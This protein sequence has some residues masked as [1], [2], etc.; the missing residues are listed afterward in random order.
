MTAS[1]CEMDEIARPEI[2]EPRCVERY[3]E[4]TYAEHRARS[5]IEHAP[6]LIPL[7]DRK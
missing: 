2:D 5:S 1:A 6:R 4:G 3:H 7:F